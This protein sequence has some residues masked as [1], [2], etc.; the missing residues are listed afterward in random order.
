MNDRIKLLIR[1]S[2]AVA[3]VTLMVMLSE[4]L[5]EREILFPETAAIALGA[6]ASEK[7]PWRITPVRMMV[8][9]TA[10]GFAGFLISVYLGIPLYFKI[11]AAF[12]LCCIVLYFS[13]STMLPMISAA[14]LPV[15]T[16][17]ESILY[18]LSVIILTAMIL[19]VQFVFVK[20]G[21]KSA[22]NCICRRGK[23]KPFFLHYAYLCAVLMVIAGAA[24]GSGKIFIIAPPLIV[25]FAELSEKQSPARKSPVLIFL[26]VTACALI[27]TASRLLI[28]NTSGL[29]LTA[30]AFAAAAFSVAL[31]FF[32]GK[33][34]P[35][36]AA[37]S[38]LPFI[39]P[40][41]ELYAYPFEIAAGMAVFTAAAMF[42]GSSISEKIIS[43]AE[44]HLRNRKGG[45]SD[46]ILP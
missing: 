4:L 41:Q 15:L 23:A 32:L 39:L 10:G 1:S 16:G 3:V 27:G 21:L 35:P 18:P 45:I 36:A 31:L 9:M 5:G 7:M 43:A 12:V 22:D 46:E 42:C 28:C 8:L 29:P 13:G 33:P 6:V 34:F 26:C 14:V 38:I 30:G 17:A 25:A 19:L 11:I 37:L 24:V 40:Q 20:T 44:K 2:A